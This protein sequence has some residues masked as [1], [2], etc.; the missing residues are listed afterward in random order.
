M[1]E[2]TTLA[3]GVV[4]LMVA[5]AGAYAF[6]MGPRGPMAQSW[7]KRLN[8]LEVAT[9]MGS[10]EEIMEAL[11][12]TAGLYRKLGKK[13]EAETVL[14]RAILM[15]KQQFGESYPGLIPLYDEFASLM[16]SM[17]RKKEGEQMRKDA[18]RIRRKSG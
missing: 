6:V 2:G 12:E 7:K 14:R 4:A 16:D 3:I 5:L 8:E 17:Q 15:G 11:R 10:P 9:R 18:E 13:W 1:D